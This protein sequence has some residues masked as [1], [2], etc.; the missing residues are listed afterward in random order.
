MS[1]STKW[2]SSRKISFHVGKCTGDSSA[3]NYV[4]A[5]LSQ[6]RQK[7]TFYKTCGSWTM[8]S[9]CT[10]IQSTHYKAM[11]SEQTCQQLLIPLVKD[12]VNLPTFNLTTMFMHCNPQITD[13]SFE[14][15]VLMKLMLFHF[16]TTTMCSGRITPLLQTYYIMQWQNTMTRLPILLGINLLLRPFK[17]LEE[18]SPI[19]STILL[20]CMCIKCF[21]F[22]IGH[23]S[24][25]VN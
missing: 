2:I 22:L 25:E 16:D 9:H 11:Y 3:L 1:Q 23:L 21:L 17:W 24:S 8:I 12:M 20:A 13:V 18:I 14:I 15:L 10:I 19:M 6:R 5:P 7:I 4:P